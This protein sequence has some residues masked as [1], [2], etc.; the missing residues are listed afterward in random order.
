MTHTNPNMLIQ[1]E[2]PE[3]M[4]VPELSQYLRISKPIL[5][6]LIREGKIDTVPL[7]TH[8][9]P[10]REIEK[11]YDLFESHR[12]GVMKIALKTEG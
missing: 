12:D 2:F 9:Y 10:L 1:T 6:G 4:T 3:M 11:A 7:I 5:Y 8:T